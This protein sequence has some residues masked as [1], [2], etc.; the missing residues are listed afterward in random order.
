MICIKRTEQMSF[1]VISWSNA[2]KS[3]L[4]DTIIFFHVHRVKV[5]NPALALLPIK[6]NVV[7]SLNSTSNAQS[8]HLEVNIPFMGVLMEG[9]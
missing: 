3:F 1:L 6:K 8:E 4:L 7:A 9:P 5:K 2:P